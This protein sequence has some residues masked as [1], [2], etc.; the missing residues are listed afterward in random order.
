MSPSRGRAFKILAGSALVGGGILIYG[1]DFRKPDD[2]DLPAKPLPDTAVTALKLFPLKIISRTFGWL[3][4]LTLPGPL[5]E[6]V[7]K[8][9]CS[10]FNCDVKEA[11]KALKEYKNLGEFFARNLVDG[12]RPADVDGDLL[13]PADGKVLSCGTV[14]AFGKLDQVKGV[15]YGLRE[16]LGADENDKLAASAVGVDS[17]REVQAVEKQLFYITI[18]LAPGDYHNFHSPADQWTVKLRRHIAGELLSVNPWLASRFPGLFTVNE[19]VI[20]L[21]EWP[22]GLFSLTAVGATNVGHIDLTF[23][24]ELKTNSSRDSLP[25][26][27]ERKYKSPGVQVSVHFR[28]FLFS[29][30]FYSFDHSL[31]MEA[32]IQF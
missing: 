16:F 4:S 27:H 1:P 20:L 23:D 15:T 24:S 17:K 29:P 3:N 8:G 9:W 28:S 10:A 31:L 7:Y 14:G 13:S 25:V 30:V 2:L 11:S 22:H 21:G 5:R 6:P 32:I 26:T 19:R 12:A 18:Y